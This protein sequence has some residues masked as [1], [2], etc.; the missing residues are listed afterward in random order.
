MVAT[1]IFHE[2]FPGAFSTVEKT[3]HVFRLK[4]IRKKPS[5][6]AGVLSFPW[7]LV[8]GEPEF[9]N[10]VEKCFV[11]FVPGKFVDKKHQGEVIFSVKEGY[12]FSIT[13]IEKLKDMTKIS[14]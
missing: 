1:I 7:L 9:S 12:L 11:F 8:V 10:E 5:H 13:A 3:H 4:N 14:Q 2:V 6:S